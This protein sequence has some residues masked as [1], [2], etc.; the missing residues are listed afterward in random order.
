MCQLI[1]W[2]IADQNSKSPTTSA[3]SIFVLHYMSTCSRSSSLRF[4]SLFVKSCVQKSSYATP[5]IIA[6]QFSACDIWTSARSTFQSKWEY[7]SEIGGNA[8]RYGR[9]PTSFRNMIR[10]SGMFLSPSPKYNCCVLHCVFHPNQ[11]NWKQ[12]K[13]QAD[14]IYEGKERKR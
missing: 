9:E 3:P 13:Q 6:V 8:I 11:E 10:S 7:N 4:A 1:R 2:F 12:R 5:D 14:V